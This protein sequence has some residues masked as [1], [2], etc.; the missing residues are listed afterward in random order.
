MRFSKAG[1]TTLLNSFQP[2]HIIGAYA[3]CWT[4]ASF[5]YWVSQWLENPRFGRVGTCAADQWKC[6]PIF[7]TA[8]DE[9]KLHWNPDEPHQFFWVDDAFG[10]IQFEPAL[11]AG[12]NRVFP[13]MVS[14]IRNG[15]RVLFTSRTYV[16][17][18]AVK[19]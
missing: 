12:W 17:R 4:T 5:C 7:A 8:P 15:A 10:Q 19:H 13:H 18:A 1:R 3:P 9:L 14:A 16:Y 11:A 2:M 6:V